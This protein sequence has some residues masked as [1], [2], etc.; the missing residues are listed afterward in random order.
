MQDTEDEETLEYKVRLDVEYYI[1]MRDTV[2]VVVRTLE[3]DERVVEELACEE[4]G[5]MLEK[6]YGGDFEVRHSTVLSIKEAG[7]VLRGAEDN[8]TADMFKGCK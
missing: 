2:E 5:D 4:A 8:E 6:Q 1:E 3:T 7:P